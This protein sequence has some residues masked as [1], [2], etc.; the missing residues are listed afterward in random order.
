MGGPGSSSVP[1]ISHLRVP[2]QP[3]YKRARPHVVNPVHLQRF[4]LIL[5]PLDKP[6]NIFRLKSLASSGCTGTVCRAFPRWHGWRRDQPRP[7][8]G[9]FPPP[10]NVPTSRRALTVRDSEHAFYTIPGPLPSVFF[11]I[12]HLYRLCTIYVGLVML[13]IEE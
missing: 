4:S 9:S 8:F 7:I 5:L 1:S 12:S 6:S 2:H 3:A 13:I 10:P 11:T